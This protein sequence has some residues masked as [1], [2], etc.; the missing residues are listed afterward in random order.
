MPTPMPLVLAMA[1]RLLTDRLH[2]RLPGEGHPD[3]RPAHGFAVG[4]LV[5][6]RGATAVELAEH[7]GVTKQGAGHLIGELER[8]GYVERVDHPADRR[9]RLVVATDKGHALVSCVN[10][11]W[12][13]EEAR[14]ADLVGARDLDGARAALQAYVDA[15]GG[16]SAP[17]RPVW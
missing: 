12:R 10:A 2:E 9:S 15:T 17:V 14:W 6:S 13:E 1:F 11:I 8:W 3:V 16:G 5:T 4:H 7:L